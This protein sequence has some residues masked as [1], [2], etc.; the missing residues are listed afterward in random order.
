MSSSISLTYDVNT[1][2]FETASSSTNE[3]AH[4]LNETERVYLHNRKTPTQTFYGRHHCIISEQKHG[5]FRIITDE[6]KIT[7]VRVEHLIC[8]YY[9]RWQIEHVM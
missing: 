5:V 4:R 8:S 6:K 3:E 7:D 1:D 9:E 2:H